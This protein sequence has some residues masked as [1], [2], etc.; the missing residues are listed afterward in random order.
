MVA[1]VQC[2]GGR[3]PASFGTANEH[4]YWTCIV[5]AA[6]PSSG[7]L[8][9]QFI[10]RYPLRRRMLLQETSVRTKLAIWMYCRVH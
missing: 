8:L 1:L 3:E 5:M 6:T 2:D 4:V 10:A 9:R 7:A